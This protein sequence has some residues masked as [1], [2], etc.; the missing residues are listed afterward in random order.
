MK[1]TTDASALASLDR[2]VAVLR[3]ETS[4]AASPN[5]AVTSWML[6]RARGVYAVLSPEVQRVCYLRNVVR[7]E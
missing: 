7:V 4:R 6:R 3:Q 1:S 5:P 2:A